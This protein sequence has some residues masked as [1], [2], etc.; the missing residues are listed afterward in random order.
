MVECTALS[1]TA[2]LAQILAHKPSLQVIPSTGFKCYKL[3]VEP[4][5]TKTELAIKGCTYDSTDVCAGVPIL[6]EQKSCNTCGENECNGTS[7][8]LGMGGLG[9]LVVAV[10]T[11]WGG[12]YKE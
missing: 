7:R 5:A 9:L 4:A 3:V 1:A 10:L 11:L 12:Y 8:Q 6:A 2:G